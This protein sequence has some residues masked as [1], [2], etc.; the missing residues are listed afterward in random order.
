MKYVLKSETLALK[1]LY[2]LQKIGYFRILIFELKLDISGTFH[3]IFL[4]CNLM[5]KKSRWNKKMRAV[6]KEMAVNLPFFVFFGTCK[7]FH[8]T[9]RLAR[10]K[11][12]K[13]V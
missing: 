6:F 8:I 7:A 3:T 13:M 5:K 11:L 4:S 2:Q 1:R 12:R 10:R 9:K